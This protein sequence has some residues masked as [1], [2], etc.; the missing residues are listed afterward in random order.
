MEMLRQLS[1]T[2]PSLLFDSFAHGLHEQQVGDAPVDE[3][4]ADSD[5]LVEMVDGQLPPGLAD[6]VTGTTSVDVCRCGEST[7]DAEY[8][9]SLRSRSHRRQG[10]PLAG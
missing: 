1:A 10:T 7:G 4:P 5:V 8:S 9:A 6:C 2:I 3:K